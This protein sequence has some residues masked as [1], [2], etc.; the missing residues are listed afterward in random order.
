ME[1]A[2]SRFD[3]FDEENQYYYTNLKYFMEDNYELDHEGD[4]KS[5]RVFDKGKEN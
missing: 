3:F 5:S 1:K 4:E 2:T